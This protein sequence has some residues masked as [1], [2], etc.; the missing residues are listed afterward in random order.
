MSK[1]RPIWVLLLAIALL[2]PPA[3]AAVAQETGSISGTLT[4]AATGDPIPNEYVTA[5]SSTGYGGTVSRSDGTYV[6]DGLPPGDYRVATGNGAEA[7]YSDYVLVYWPDAPSYFEA[8]PISVA[9]GED[10]TG[11]DFALE[12]GGVVTGTVTNAWTGEPIGPSF[13]GISRREY[14]EWMGG[15]GYEVES[16]GTFRIGGLSGE[17]RLEYYETDYLALESEP[18]E[19]RP[20]D[21]LTFDLEATPA[22]GTPFATVTGWVCEGP[23]GSCMYGEFEAGEGRPMAGVAVEARSESGAILGTTTTDRN[24]WFML[25]QLPPGDIVVTAL[26]P[27]GFTLREPF[28]VTLGPNESAWDVELGFDRVDVQYVMSSR[29][30]PDQIEVGDEA[31]LTLA[32]AFPGSATPDVPFDVTNVVVAVHLPSGLEYVDHRGDGPFV[33]GTG[34]WTIPTLSYR[35]RAEMTI[36]VLAV[37]EM[38]YRLHAEIVSADWPDADVTFGDGRGADYTSV[39]LTVAAPPVEPPVTDQAIIGGSVWRDADEDGELG[40]AESAIAGV[41]V[42]AT[43][44]AG[45]AYR[46]VSGDDGTFRIEQLPA[47]TYRVELDPTTLPEDLAA[48]PEVFVA[49]LAGDTVFLGADFGLREIPAGFPWTPVLIGAALLLL[50]GGLTAWLLIRS[51]RPK[52]EEPAEGEGPEAEPAPSLAGAGDRED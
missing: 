14:G 45:N 1:I 12:V 36:T 47:G 49:A 4:N 19:I 25:E 46:T 31:E 21:E 39:A 48:P 40:P 9:A 13:I 30:D 17:Y 41:S 11:I 28:R 3:T 10:I 51:R 32:L 6:I 38:D 37:E 52:T 24:G 2:V 35:Q 27:G 29:I 18:F 23:E 16:D 7:D 34:R 50:T 20:G 33:S 15:M 5:N 22:Y 42:V 44:E 8:D 43:D 26:P